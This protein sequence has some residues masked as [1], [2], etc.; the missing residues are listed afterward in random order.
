[1]WI[2]QQSDFLAIELV[3]GHIHVVLSLGIDIIIHFGHHTSS[4]KND[5]TKTTIRINPNQEVTRSRLKTTPAEASLITSGTVLRW[6]FGGIGD[7][8][9]ISRDI[10]GFLVLVW[11]DIWHIFGYS[12][13]AWGDDRLEGGSLKIWKLNEVPSSRW[14][15]R[16]AV[17]TWW[18]TRPLPPLTRWATSRLNW[19]ASFS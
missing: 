8:L 1:M 19:T 12:P 4:P 18:L 3:G 5:D 6:Y 7:F 16:E 10:W 17:W 15:E 9:A 14:W 11:Y 13:R 2:F